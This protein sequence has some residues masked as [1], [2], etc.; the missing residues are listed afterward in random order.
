MHTIDPDIVLFSGG[1]IAAGPKF[2]EMI[3]SDV[4][5]MAF[6]V[7][8]ARTRVEY[9]ELGGKAGVIGAAGC[10]RMAHR[11]PAVASS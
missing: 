5:S 10:A 11:K 9:A 7:P 2:L 1:M 4:Q 3:R 6:P 8:A